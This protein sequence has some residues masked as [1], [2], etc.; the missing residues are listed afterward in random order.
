MQ[1]AQSRFLALCQE[2]SWKN[3]AEAAAKRKTR[4]DDTG[5]AEKEE[6][7]DEIGSE[8]GGEEGEGGRLLPADFFLPPEHDLSEARL[9]RFKQ[10][11]AKGDKE[12]VR[13][14]ETLGMHLSR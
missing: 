8:R 2:L 7:D 10:M 14:H 11:V 3:E 4:G 6:E 5:E 9:A 12:L 13:I 1:E